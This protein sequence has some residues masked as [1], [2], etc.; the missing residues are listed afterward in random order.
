MPLLPSNLTLTLTL[1]ATSDYWPG[2][3]RTKLGMDTQLGGWGNF[4]RKHSRVM[5]LG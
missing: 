5:S 4:G 2:Q 1:S 3:L